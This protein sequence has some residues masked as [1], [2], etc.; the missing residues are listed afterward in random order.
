[1]IKMPV[2]VYLTNPEFIDEAHGYHITA[3]E[4]PTIK[5]WLLVT[6][7]EIEFEPVTH[8]E[9]TRK[10]VQALNAKFEE[11][12]KKFEDRCKEI[13]TQI[14]KFEALEYDSSPIIEG[15]S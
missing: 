8:A 9:G 7:L 10:A 6:K 11:E 15:Q 5:E 1:M 2:Y 3:Y 12:R 14:A 13:R 4:C